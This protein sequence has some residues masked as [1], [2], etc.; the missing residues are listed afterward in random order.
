MYRFNLP[1]KDTCNANST[2]QSDQ[3]CIESPCSIRVITLREDDIFYL[4]VNEEEINSVKNIKF[5]TNQIENIRHRIS[6]LEMNGIN[7]RLTIHVQCVG[8]S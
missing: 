2:R 1:G 8:T 7:M 3:Y 4:K 6:K 5:D